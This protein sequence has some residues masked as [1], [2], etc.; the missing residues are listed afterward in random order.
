[1]EVHDIIQVPWS[2]SLRQGSDLLCKDFFKAVTL[3]IDTV[4][5]PIGIRMMDLP[6]D[7]IQNQYLIG[8]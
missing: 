4:V 8:R 6:Q 7:W 5:R 1:M 3:D 2:F